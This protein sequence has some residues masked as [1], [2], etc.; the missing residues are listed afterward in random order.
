M[1][2][3]NLFIFT[4]INLF[5]VFFYEKV[6]KNKKAVVQNGQNKHKESKV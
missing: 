5:L 4:L 6:Q 3:E 1:V 2:Y